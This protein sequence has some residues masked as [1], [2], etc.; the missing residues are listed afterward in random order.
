MWEHVFTCSHVPM[1]TWTWSCACVP[2]FLT[3]LIH[4]F[5]IYC[6]HVQIFPC[7]R[8][9]VSSG[10]SC[11]ST[12]MF[13][14]FPFNGS[15]FMHAIHLCP[16]AQYV[17]FNNFGTPE[18]PEMFNIMFA[19]TLEASVHIKN[20]IKDLYQDGL[21]RTTQTFDHVVLIHTLI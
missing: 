20:P 6:A 1:S 9:H 3:F 10:H 18:S 17:Y 19:N 4:A 14:M 11:V 21:G 15:M 7:R 12:S 13:P 16:Y 8:S 5:P 2:V